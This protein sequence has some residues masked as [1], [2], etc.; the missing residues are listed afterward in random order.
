MKQFKIMKLL[1]V[2]LFAY[3]AFSCKQ[4]VIETKVSKELD[5]ELKIVSNQKALLILFPCFPCDIEHTKQEAKFIEHID[6]QGITTLLFNF[7]QKL[8]LSDQEKKNIIT[9]LIDILNQHQLNKVN[10]YIGGFSSGGNVAMLI[11]NELMKEQ[12]SIQPKGVFVVDS[13]IDLEELYKSAKKDIEENVSKAAVEE[14]K[15][16]IELFNKELGAPEDS[17]QNYE[18]YSPYLMSK[19]SNKN[20]QFLK[21]IKIR[22]YCEPDIEWQSSNRNRTYED[23]N[24]F[25]LKKMASHLKAIGAKSVE[26]IETENRGFRAN[27][28]KHPHS[29][30]IVEKESLVDWM[31]N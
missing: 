9:R 20:I 28:Q 2:F 18:Y 7:N 1:F 31:L 3:V 15:F 16:L 12:N 5:Y 11:G 10:F 22:L 8:Y 30:N 21:N 17:I 23:L 27:G 4:S 19:N 6:Q 29:W 13:P 25:K 24:A 14:G 26:F